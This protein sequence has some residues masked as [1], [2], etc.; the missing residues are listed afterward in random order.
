MGS[1]RRRRATARGAQIAAFAAS[2]MMASLGL[3]LQRGRRFAGWS[4]LVV[5]VSVSLA[6]IADIR[7][8]RADGRDAE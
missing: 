3:V 8:C 4:V 6:M 2:A 7:L 1:A 5:I